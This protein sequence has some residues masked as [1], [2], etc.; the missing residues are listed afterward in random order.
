MDLPP[1]M[2]TTP[3]FTEKRFTANPLGDEGECSPG[4][5]E[6]NPYRS[7]DERE[8]VEAYQAKAEQQ[9]RD[10]GLFQTSGLVLPFADQPDSPTKGD[11][12]FVFDDVGGEVDELRL[13]F[14]DSDGPQFPQF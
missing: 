14:A 5:N 13:P 12:P 7:A 8:V 2:Q 9:E 4:P 11:D 3:G 6:A 1:L 10:N